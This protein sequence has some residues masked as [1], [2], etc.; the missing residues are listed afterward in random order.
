M[1]T[2]L[3]YIEGTIYAKNIGL[4]HPSPETKHMTEIKEAIIH[5]RQLVK[6]NAHPSVQTRAQNFLTRAHSDINTVIT[7]FSNFQTLS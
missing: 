7:E 3:S 1:A 4:L 2:L 6:I 5:V